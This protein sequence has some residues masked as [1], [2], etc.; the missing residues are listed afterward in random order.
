M[1]TRDSEHMRGIKNTHKKNPL[2]KHMK[3]VHGH[4][5]ENIK[6]SMRMKVFFKKPMTRQTDEG[7]R[8]KNTHN[9]HL[10]NLKN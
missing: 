8:I 9:D 2:W 6:F 4:E 3:N 10:L 7:L 1:F 5:I